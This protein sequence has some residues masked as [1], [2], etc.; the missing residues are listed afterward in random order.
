M[1]AV[2]RNQVLA[3][4]HTIGGLFPADMLQRIAEGK[5]VSGAMSGDYGLP[6]SRSVRD[7]AERSWEQLKPLWKELR[8]QLP[9]GTSF[10]PTSRA[11]ND[12]LAPLFQ[13]LGFGKLEE[14]GPLGIPAD[15]DPNKAFVISH[16][17]QHALVHIVTWGAELDR[18]VDGLSGAA[19]V[20]PQSL[21][22][23]CLNRTE[24]HLWAIVT[25]GRQI[26]LLRDSNALATAS[27]V[28]FDLEAI[29][30]GELFS[31]FVLLFR[32]LH[33]SRFAT[34]PGAAPSTC[35]LEKWRAEAIASGVRALKHLRQGVQEAINVL[36][37]GFL[38]HPR[39]GLLNSGE[40]G[41]GE[42]DV[43]AFHG[44]L[45]RLVYRLI[46]LFVAEDRDLLHPPTAD[47]L[48]KKRYAEYFSTAK[49]RRIAARRRGTSHGDLYEALRIVLGALGDVDGRP[50]LGL[51]GLGGLFDDKPT[52]AP[53]RGLELANE[54]LLEAVRRLSRVRDAEAKRWRSVDYRNMDS[55]ELGSIYE[56]LLE[57][58]PTYS[59]SEL[60]F[61]LEERQGN[62]RKKTGSYYTPSML[63][64][65][66]LD[67]SL[68]PVIDDA[69]KRGETKAA[70]E[71]KAGPIAKDTIVEELLSLTVCDPACGSAH[72]LVAAAR[73]IA[74]RVAAVRESN[75]EP[76]VDAVRHAL[77]EVITRCIYGVDL[78][79][80]AVDLAKVSLWLEALEPGKPLGFLDAHV[81]LGNALIGATPRLLKEGIPDKAFEPIEG[82]DSKLA[83]F[84]E[85][86][87]K[88]ERE[89]GQDTL[90]GASVETKVTNMDFASGMRQISTAPSGTLLQMREQEEA[91]AAWSGGADYQNAVHVANAWCAAF[92]WRKAADAPTPITE[93]VFRALEDPKGA[94]ASAAVHEEIKRLRTEYQFFHWHLEFPEVFT[95]SDSA[96]GLD[97]A[98]GWSGGFDCV[99]ANPPWDD[100]A[101]D[102]TEYFSVVDPEI[103]A[104]TSRAQKP[105]I[106]AWIRDFPEVGAQYRADRRVVDSTTL[107]IHNS[108]AYIDTSKGNLK[109]DLLFV[110][111]FS[112]LVSPVGR[113]GA[114]VPTR[115]ATTDQ[116]KQLFSGLAQSGAIVSLYDFENRK[117]FFDDVDRRYKFCLLSLAGS[118]LRTPEARYAFFLLDTTDLDD[119]NRMITLT[120]ESIA[121]INPNTGTLPIFRTPKDFEITASAY[122]AMPVLWR[123]GIE[124][125][126]PW[127]LHL[128]RL[129]DMTYDSHL[130]RDRTQLEQDDWRLA[131]NVFFKAG[132]RMLP[133]YEGKM[134]DFY[135]HRAADVVKSL[136]AVSRQYQPRYLSV[137][138][139]QDATRYPIPLSWIQDDGYV[140]APRRGKE[141]RRP[142]VRVR[143]EQVKWDR[144]WLCGW[145]DVT[146]ATNER[147]A[148]PA[149]I[150]YSAPI[151]T[152][153][154]MF[155]RVAA[156]LVAG[157]IA[158]QSSLVFDF[159]ARQKIGGMHMNRFIWEQ[160]PVPTPAMLESHIPFILPRVLELVY[161]AYDM[162]P[163]ARD[164][165]DSGEPFRWDED[166]RAQLR[167]ELDAYFFYLYGLDRDDTD[168]VLET[169]QSDS[170][171]GLKN[172]EIAKY[173]S[174][175]TK[176]LVL[177]EYDRMAAALKPPSLDPSMPLV[178]GS[179]YTSPLMPPPGQGP[180]HPAAERG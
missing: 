25:N 107:F 153:L 38:R 33:V 140:E 19:G 65:K 121:A 61:T 94:A 162:T 90:F 34:Q 23:E 85:N 177:T 12:W 139:L 155:P 39:N 125:G 59:A 73:R 44:A 6:S 13:E 80:M 10:D 83:R 32:L 78:N 2:A 74:K 159:V 171:G 89:E 57:S 68:D 69:V 27:Y 135:N 145:C 100:I 138:D 92:M 158:A 130:F 50:E 30:D 93:S 18:R 166:R 108:G 46:F 147:T 161:T 1:S 77:H 172:N 88:R 116:A 70:E 146:A 99:V 49:L 120:A 14:V 122:R 168:Y 126:N 176:D 115:V 31:D 102:D 51:V 157:L 123:A 7:A 5:D 79:P 101:F 42:F 76:P 21:V 72:F 81:K 167:A 117:P 54:H 105:R 97:P 40:H 52:D 20:P 29:F 64:E 91:Y 75:P 17:W 151:N 110:E 28:E 114:I 149:F 109:T 71:G 16:R 82:D 35:W 174:Y 56:W 43:Y 175:R 148:I 144:E 165:G 124:N 86:Q 142:G 8:E 131:G 87:N 4:V 163:L 9:E 53:L 111:R 127:N 134:V 55:E 143:L 169:F 178:D 41:R 36:G 67:E 66:V 112:S 62:N 98:V 106:A 48:A 15:S 113:V 3:S 11:M 58:V 180:R 118:S 26:R 119:V 179:T 150:P 24:A 154:L 47:E 95:V 152:F 133:V 170:G 60:T 45:L 164:L 129:F 173:G 156:G 84:Y 128:T 103:A 37:T 137:R 63:I 141:A 22:Q 136:T 104:L 132:M 160:L 96:E